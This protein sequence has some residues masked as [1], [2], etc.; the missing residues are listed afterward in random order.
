M[1]HTQIGQN[2]YLRLLKNEMKNQ[3]KK[4]SSFTQMRL[5]KTKL[6]GKN[7]SK[8]TNCTWH[9][10]IGGSYATRRWMEQISEKWCKEKELKKRYIKL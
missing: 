8:A 7:S 2:T 1:Q 10:L 4:V 5:I 6:S 3:L 9:G